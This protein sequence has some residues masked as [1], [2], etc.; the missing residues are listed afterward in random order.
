VTTIDQ[1]K[2]SEHEVKKL[3]ISIENSDNKSEQKKLRKQLQQLN[4]DQDTAVMNY[5]ET[6]DNSYNALT[7]E[8]FDLLINGHIEFV[9]TRENWGFFRS[10]ATKLNGDVHENGF[11][12]AQTTK[13]DLALFS[14][15]KGFYPLG[16]R[17]LVNYFGEADLIITKRAYK[18]FGSRVPQKYIGSIDPEGNIQMKTTETYWETEGSIY[19]NK[20][21]GDFFSGNSAKRQTFLKNKE[22]L[23]TKILEFRTNLN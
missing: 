19:V 15:Q 10:H 14:F 5:L 1:I 22:K 13:T 16:Y 2:Q 18:F 6:N 12:Y 11:F 8:N 4:Y 17:G 20:I 7:Q 9:V 3:L 23:K 21:I